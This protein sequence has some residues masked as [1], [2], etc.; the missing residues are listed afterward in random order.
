MLE[1]GVKL[2]LKFS[3]LIYETASHKA[4]KEVFPGIEIECCCFFFGQANWRNVVS[5]GFPQRCI[6]D[7]DFTLKV[8]MVTA[9]AFMPADRIYRGFLEVSMIMPK[10]FQDLFKIC[11]I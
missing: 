6:E 8:R 2:I 4:A 5:L 1:L 7:L 10:E 11:S 9:L 3:V